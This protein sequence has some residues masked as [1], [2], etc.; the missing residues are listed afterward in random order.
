MQHMCE[1][2]EDREG[3]FEAKKITP[4][5]FRSASSYYFRTFQVKHYFTKENVGK[6]TRTL[7]SG[8]IQTH[9]SKKS[10]SRPQLS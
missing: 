10:T 1:L 5:H 7:T 9:N 8:A 2:A 6:I 3:I 4:E